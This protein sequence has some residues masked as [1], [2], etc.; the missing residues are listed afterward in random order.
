MLATGLL[1]ACGGGDSGSSSAD[2]VAKADSACRQSNRTV[3][4]TPPRTARE[5]ARQTR[6]DVAART[7]LDQ[8]LRALDVP[9]KK[10]ADFDRYSAQTKKVI[11]WVRLQQRAAEANL[12]ARF[13][14]YGRSLQRAVQA[15]E[16]TA[17]RLGFKVCGRSRPK[18]G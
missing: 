9:K 7:K 4:T 12:E 11:G 14:R 13:A 3:P 8:K 6:Q 18:P 17:K 1:A 10:Q 2:F 16:A 15:R 5:A